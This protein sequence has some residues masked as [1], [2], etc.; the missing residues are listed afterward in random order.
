MATNWSITAQIR[1]RKNNDQQKPGRKWNGGPFLI[2]P[3]AIAVTVFFI[4]PALFALILSFSQFSGGKPHLFVA[5]FKNY[6]DVF[7]D[8]NFL[9]AYWNVI[10]FSVLAT[11]MGFIGSVSLALL[12]SL[13]HDRLGT[14]ARSIFFLPGAFNGPALALVFLF[15]L[16]PSISPFRAIY[17]SFGWKVLADFVNPGNAIQILAVI[18]FYLMS[19]GWIAI[20]CSAL[21]SVSIEQ[22]EAA[23]IDGCNPWQLAWS[24][25]RPAIMGF[26]WFMLIQLIA[27]NLMIFS[28]PYLISTAL[29]GTPQSQTAG[30]NFIN[31]FWS[32]N[33]LGAYYIRAMGDFGRSSVV[34]ITQIFITFTSSVFIVTKTGA[35]ITDIKD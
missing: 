18:R 17:Q 5:G 20:F 31:P 8:S 3:Y 11:A 33:M 30:G 23:L 22:I 29:G 25:R 4:G 19:G 12:L 16:D 1:S 34:S 6:I 15:M 35:F 26:I 21:E 2:T 13:T 10:R 9:K 7:K 24:I 32:P 27:S 28:E 14:I